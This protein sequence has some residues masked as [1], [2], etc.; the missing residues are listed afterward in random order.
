MN[1][2]RCSPLTPVLERMHTNV[3]I[4]L[5]TYNSYTHRVPIYIIAG[6][7]LELDGF[8]TVNYLA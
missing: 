7:R 4:L 1:F 2:I 8:S 3:L 6:S 5:P